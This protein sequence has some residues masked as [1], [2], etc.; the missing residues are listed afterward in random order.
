MLA[1]MY[2]YIYKQRFKLETLDAEVRCIEFSTDRLAV[3]SMEHTYHSQA[4]WDS[5]RDCTKRCYLQMP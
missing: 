3:Q 5:P 4:L 2:I 1:H